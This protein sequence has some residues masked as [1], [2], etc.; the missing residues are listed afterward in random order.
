MGLTVQV[1][2][3]W[4][5]KNKY[6]VGPLYSSGFTPTDSTNRESNG[7]FD[8]HLGIHRPGGLTEGTGLCHF[9]RN[10]TVCVDCGVHGGPGT[11]PRGYQGWL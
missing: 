5:L 1:Y 4:I 8:L 7:I 2:L 10:L 11:H 9:I 3:E 6:T